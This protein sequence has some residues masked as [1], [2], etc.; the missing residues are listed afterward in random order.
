MTKKVHIN[1]SGTNVMSIHELMNE[2]KQEQSEPTIDDEE[3]MNL[4]KESISVSASSPPQKNKPVP[5]RVS[6]ANECRDAAIL[7]KYFNNKMVSKFLKTQGFDYTPKRIH[8]LD[9]QAKGLLLLQVRESL[10]SRYNEQIIQHIAKQGVFIYEQFVSP[11]YDCGGLAKTL[12]ELDQWNMLMVEFSIECDL[13]KTPLYA[14]IGLCL[15]Q[16]TL[17]QHKI[18]EM[19]AVGEKNL[20]KPKPKPKRK[21]K[22]SKCKV[23]I[24]TTVLEP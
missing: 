15:A 7:I 24:D 12:N 14:R 6:H 22:K 20:K 23:E 16:A 3:I 5:R 13:P 11:V 19:L 8:G 17:M 4:L 10:S 9:S 21:N 2:S 1:T 18:N